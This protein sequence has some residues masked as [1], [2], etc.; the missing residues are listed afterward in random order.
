M[1]YT[2]EDLD[3]DLKRRAV[4][5]D[6]AIK[7]SA[8]PNSYSRY[9]VLDYAQQFDAFLRGEKQQPVLVPDQEGTANG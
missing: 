8:N 3:N 5:L 6:A 4:A 9:T 2:R 1:A 7:F